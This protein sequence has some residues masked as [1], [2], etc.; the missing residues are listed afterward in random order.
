MGGGG[1]VQPGSGGAQGGSAGSPSRGGTSNQGGSSDGGAAGGDDAGANTAGG[2]GGASGGSMGG[3]AGAPEGGTS[4]LAGA[5]GAPEWQ[6]MGDRP[7]GNLRVCDGPVLH[8][9]EASACSLPV[10]DEDVLGL[11]GAA[12]YDEPCDDSPYSGNCLI[13]DDCTVDADCG[14]GAYC[15]YGEY[16]RALPNDDVWVHYCQPACQT[17]ADCLPTE[18]CACDTFTQNATR[19]QISLGVCRPA[20]CRIDADCGNGA[21]CISPLNPRSTWEYETRLEEF[22]CRTPADECASPSDCPQP[23]PGDCTHMA[24]CSYREDRHMCWERGTADPC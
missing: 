20:T 5:G 2:R 18:L 11:G 4:A 24:F 10:R 7:W 22:H 16:T 12:G 23:Y 3:E 21:L 17:D 19:E 6:C 9:P 15:L 1:G 8:R 14:T 13:R